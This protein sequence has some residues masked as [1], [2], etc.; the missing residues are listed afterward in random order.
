MFVSGCFGHGLGTKTTLK[1]SIN[2]FCN[3]NF[4][5]SI[6]VV[7]CIV[8]V[9]T[10]DLSRG[11]FTLDAATCIE[12]IPGTISTSPKISINLSTTSDSEKFTSPVKGMTRVSVT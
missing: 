9:I 10:L 5:S 3:S 2:A 6:E 7:T 11:T 12:L 8:I 1:P 4:L